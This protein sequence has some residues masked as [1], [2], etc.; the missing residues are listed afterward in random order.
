MDVLL[1]TSFMMAVMQAKIDLVPE[2]RKFGRPKLFVLDLVLKELEGL[3]SAGGKD[4]TA[5]RLA[6]SFLK[7]EAAEVIEA[8][9][10]QTDKK[11]VEYSMD[12]NMVVCTID[13]ELKDRLLMGGMEVITIRQGKYLV[14]AE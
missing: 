6:L 2:L 9:K 10:G 1:D 11:I 8:G 3:S 7:R 12:R 13:K 5:A 4:G 14:R